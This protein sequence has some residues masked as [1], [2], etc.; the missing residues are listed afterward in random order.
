MADKE[1]LARASTT[2]RA[3]SDKVWKALTDPSLIKQ[4]MFGT[5]VKPAALS[6]YGTDRSGSLP[7]KVQSFAGACALLSMVN[8]LFP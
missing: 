8:I 7:G 2:I 1:L 5:N 3:P 4:Y 6:A